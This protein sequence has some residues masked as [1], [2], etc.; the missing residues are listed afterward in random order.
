MS[1]TESEHNM[2][3]TLTAA[4]IARLGATIPA[5][6]RIT[7]PAAREL[8]KRTKDDAKRAALVAAQNAAERF[9]NYTDSQSARIKL[10][11]TVHWPRARRISGE[12][13]AMRETFRRHAKKSGEYA[14]FTLSIRA[15]ED[16]TIRYFRMSALI[17]RVY[18]SASACGRFPLSRA[19]MRTDKGTILT[20]SA[21]KRHFTFAGGRDW[22]SQEYDPSDI[23]QGA[24]L[25]AI[26]NGDTVSGV[27][28]YGSIFR[29]V[30]A[31]RATLTAANN[32]EYAARKRAAL[33]W[34]ERAADEWPDMTDKHVLRLI[35]TR[36]HGSLDDHRAALA[37]AHRDAELE[38]MDDY[39]T[40]SAREDSMSH[41]NAEEFHIVL[42]DYLMRG[43][44]LA[45]VAS[46]LGL[47]VELIA[48]RAQESRAQSLRSTDTGI[49][50]AMRS[51]DMTRE[52]ERES[53]I[54]A[55]Q[56]EHA[57]TLRAR[58][59]A[60]E[61]RIYATDQSVPLSAYAARNKR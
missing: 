54:D 28:T 47:T 17:G 22:G 16:L 57:A 61:T 44:Q 36:R 56:A 24:F 3:L 21:F 11:H 51:V 52:A 26:E 14:E 2:S 30:Q 8:A 60:L 5:R 38:R 25:R 34:T 48:Q 32:A 50:H 1:P 29:Y 43:A 53:A 20:R 37:I 15:F 46:A 40:R 55:A 18:A 12:L 23:V 7:D 35:G 41:G 49:D 19:D 9:A 27:P 33:G 6:T 10:L 45:D 59:I 31:E 4:D 42:A 39:V 13:S 58:R